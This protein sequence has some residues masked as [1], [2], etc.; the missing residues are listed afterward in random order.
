MN[1]VFE[2]VITLPNSRLFLIAPGSGDPDLL[3][4]CFAAANAAGDVASLLISDPDI[5]GHLLPAAQ[6]GDVAVL[7]QDNSELAT[8]LGADGIEV[9]ADVRSYKECR[10]RIGTDMAIGANCGTDRHAAMEMAEAGADYVRIS[11]FEPGPDNE[12][13]IA[14]WSQLFEIPCVTAEALT[15]EQITDAV[16]M[17]ADF[18]R[19]DDEMWSSPA[20]A[21]KIIS[22][23]MQAIETANEQANKKSHK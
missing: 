21:T 12:P 20:Q 6:S 13:L 1:S 16:R 11:S 8:R 3:A 19:P 2:S 9:N 4:D 22:E 17:R 7:I 10:D 15:A 23:A 14:W 18:V 5:A